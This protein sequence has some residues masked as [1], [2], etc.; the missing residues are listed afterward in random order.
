MRKW[1]FS[2]GKKVKIEI[3]Q[4]FEVFTFSFFRFKCLFLSEFSTVRDGIGFKCLLMA[5]TTLL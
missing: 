3:S 4:H 1:L 2:G 5:H